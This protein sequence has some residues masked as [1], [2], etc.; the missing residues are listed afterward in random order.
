MS[1]NVPTTDP[2]V[3]SKVASKVASKV[4]VRLTVN[5]ADREVAVRPRDTLAQALREECGLTGVK[6]GCD[7]GTCGCCTVLLDGKA[8]LSCLTLAAEA[9]GR[10]ITTIEGM[11]QGARMHP[12]QE[13][14]ATCGGSQCGFCT[15]G[16]VM[17]TAALLDANPSPTREQIRDAISGN[18][19][20]CTGY[21][22]I[23]D[24][25][26]RAA[27]RMREASTPADGRL[28]PTA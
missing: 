24:A 13:A 9:E 11:G 18:L 3:V 2:N 1:K 10:E 14:F 25:I 5:G 19:C 8:A 23:I 26:E 16:F 22:K 17:T 15:P 20:R 28:Q 12:I 7:L 6:V 27:G 4:I 21:V